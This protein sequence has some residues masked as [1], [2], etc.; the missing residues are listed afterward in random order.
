M[1]EGS[2]FLW[3]IGKHLPNYTSSHQK[4]VLFIVTGMRIS[5]AEEYEAVLF[6][7]VI[8]AVPL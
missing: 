1:V 6:F 7:Y 3:N 5:D 2:P 8:I 4:L